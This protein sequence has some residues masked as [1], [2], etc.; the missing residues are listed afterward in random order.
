MLQ[1]TSGEEIDFSDVLKVFK[2][3]T[4][5]AGKNLG[6]PLLGTLMPGAPAD[7]MAVRGNPSE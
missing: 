3:A 6:L 1:L 7:I 4:S 5:E 2:A